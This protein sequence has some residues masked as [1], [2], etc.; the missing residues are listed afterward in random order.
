MTASSK[1]ICAWVFFCIGAGFY[2][3]NAM[4]VAFLILLPGIYAF[5]VCAQMALILWWM[6]AY[7]A[8]EPLIWIW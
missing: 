7:W 1:I 5:K 6:A 4:L 3:H 8:G 2:Y